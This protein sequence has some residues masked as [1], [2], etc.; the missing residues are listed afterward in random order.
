[1]GWPLGSP[2]S[3]W[4]SVEVG[5]DSKSFPV[6]GRRY[7]LSRS[8]SPR[9]ELLTRS[10]YHSS[11]DS[12]SSN[13]TD[14]HVTADGIIIMFHDPSL[15]RTT[16]GKGLIKQQ[17]WHDGIEHVRTTAK[18]QQQ[19]PT[20]RS[21]CDLLMKPENKHVKLNV[22][23]ALQRARSYDLAA[24]APISTCS[25]RCETR[26]RPRSPVPSHEDGDPVVQ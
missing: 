23:A 10:P 26:K 22:S 17:P 20:F 18:P 25:D 11:R 19:L 24:D 5:T 6:A 3:H 16:D 7:K 8:R 2:L 1:M 4:R 9:M 12:L 14:V 15:E 21:V 13:R